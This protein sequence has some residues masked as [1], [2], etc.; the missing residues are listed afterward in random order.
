MCLLNLPEGSLEKMFKMLLKD[1]LRDKGYMFW[2]F[3]WPILLYFIYSVTIGNI[4]NVDKV[5]FSDIKVVIVEDNM[6]TAIFNQIGFSASNGSLEEA[7]SKLDAKE[8]DGYITKDSTLYVNG[9]NEKNTIIKEVLREYKNREVLAK[10]I[11]G[12]P[13]FK[14]NIVSKS[15]VERPGASPEVLFYFALVSLFILTSSTVGVDLY[16]KISADKKEQGKRL[17][18]VPKSKLKMFF[19]GYLTDALIHIAISI[20]I[21]IF[22]TYVLDIPFHGMLL[23]IMGLII[24]GTFF[25]LSFGIIVSSLLN[26][27][28]DALTGIMVLINLI[29]CFFGGMMNIQILHLV[30]TKLPFLTY[31]NPANLISKALQGV[32][33]YQNLDMYLENLGILSIMAAVCFALSILIV[34]RRRYESL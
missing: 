31:I 17:N 10:D 20:V 23:E 19:E 26:F 5:D 1:A 15:I 22:V 32:Y 3:L 28:A 18:I 25:S 14:Q 11:K 9:K 27:K 29:L 24:V 34:R 21:T 7:K 6:K 33:Y 30:E 16:C 13:I 2:A 4:T 12:F 8:I